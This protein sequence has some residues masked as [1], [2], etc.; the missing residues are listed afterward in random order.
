MV[1]TVR[2]STRPRRCCTYPGLRQPVRRCRRKLA[3]S[4]L[5]MKRVDPARAR[6]SAL[7]GVLMP[8]ASRATAASAARSSLLPS[9]DQ[10]FSVRSA[11]HLHGSTPHRKSGWCQVIERSG[12]RRSPSGQTRPHALPFAMEGPVLER[13]AGT[14]ASAS[15]AGTTS[16]LAATRFRERPAMIAGRSQTS[17]LRMTSTGP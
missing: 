17:A 14:G 1:R 9:M 7:H 15:S 2:R 16:A 13:M 12:I 11:I 4:S 8:A 5:K 6:V 3:R 10:F